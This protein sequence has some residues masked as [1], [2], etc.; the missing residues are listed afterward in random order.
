MRDRIYY[1]M[2][3]GSIYSVSQRVVDNGIPP[4]EGAV[5]L[6]EDE[7]EAFILQV[8]KD[9]ELASRLTAEEYAN[10]VKFLEPD[11]VRVHAKSVEIINSDLTDEQKQEAIKA[12]D[13][14]IPEEEKL[15]YTQI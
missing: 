6:P 3:D 11:S 4:L 5:D 10:G 7:K 8:Q 15:A 9:Q 12:I 13:G 1:K 14:S 2:P